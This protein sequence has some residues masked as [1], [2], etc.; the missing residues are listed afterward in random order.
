MRK[1]G[2]F[3]F[4]R[5]LYFLQVEKHRFLSEHFKNKTFKYNRRNS[6]IQDILNTGNFIRVVEKF[7]DS[8]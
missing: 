2:R 4:I 5:K 8:D 1:L 6:F 7:H 3:F